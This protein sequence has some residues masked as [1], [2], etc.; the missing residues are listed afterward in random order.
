MKHNL[1]SEMKCQ[2]SSFSVLSGKVRPLLLTVESELR[3]KTSLV[4]TGPFLTHQLVV[5]YSGIPTFED[6]QTGGSVL[7]C[8]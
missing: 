3:R 8:A 1:L 2:Y 6:Y 5:I 7:H 4:L